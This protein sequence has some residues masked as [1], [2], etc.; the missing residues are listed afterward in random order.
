MATFWGAAVSQ[1]RILG[2]S[3]RSSRGLQSGGFSLPATGFGSLEALACYSLWDYSLGLQSPSS[4]FWVPRCAHLGGYSLGAAAWRATV[5]QQR[6]LFPSKHSPATLWG[7]YSLGG[8][9]LPAMDFGSLDALIWGATV[10]VITV[11]G[12]HSPRN[13]FWVP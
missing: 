9:S 8:Y 5:S 11:W 3:M 7:G 12:L 1:Q 13:I 10:W 2:P 6:M 4:G